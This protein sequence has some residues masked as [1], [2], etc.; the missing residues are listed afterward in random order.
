MRQCGNAIIALYTHQGCHF[1][2]REKSPQHLQAATLDDSTKSQE[3]PPDV[4]MTVL[5]SYTLLCASA[6]LQ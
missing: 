6:P 5:F 2:H 1:D 4:G 3:I